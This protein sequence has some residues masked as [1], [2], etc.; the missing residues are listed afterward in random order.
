M[1]ILATAS[2]LCIVRRIIKH[3][4]YFAMSLL[5]VD[6]QAPDAP[7]QFVR[8][9][10]NCGFVVLKNHPLDWVLIESIYYAESMD[11]RAVKSRNLGDQCWRYVTRDQ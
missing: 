9:L 2:T 11:R 8:S 6:F 5:T 4:H 7:K 10:Y 3:A 1:C